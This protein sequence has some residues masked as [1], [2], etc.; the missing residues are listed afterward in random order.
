VLTIFPLKYPWAFRGSLPKLQLDHNL[1]LISCYV[2]FYACHGMGIHIMA[3]GRTRRC[4]LLCL[5]LW[6]VLQWLLL[7]H[8]LRL[9][10]SLKILT[11]WRLFQPR[12]RRDLLVSKFALLV[13][14]FCGIH[15]SMNFQFLPWYVLWRSC[16]KLSPSLHR[17]FYSVLDFFLSLE[18]SFELP[19]YVEPL[20][21]AFVAQHPIPSF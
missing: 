4:F 6:C 10:N 11:Q 5:R 7:H 14:E 8:S 9:S 21:I 3:L 20:A 18:K 15:L 1:D 2:V 13:N 16:D 19:V 12:L 17:P